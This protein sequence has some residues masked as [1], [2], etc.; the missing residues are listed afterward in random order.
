MVVDTIGVVK[1]TQVERKG[2]KKKNLE[3]IMYLSI[4]M[5]VER[6]YLRNKYEHDW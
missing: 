5:S 2:K 3:K 4:C 1:I 6:K